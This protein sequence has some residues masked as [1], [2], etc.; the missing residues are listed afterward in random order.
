MSEEL[1]GIASDGKEFTLE[2]PEVIA[3][4]KQYPDVTPEAA[5]GSVITQYENTLNQVSSEEVSE[6]SETED[7]EATEET[8]KETFGEAEAES[9]EAL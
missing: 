3:Y 4:R 1:K 5:I 8:E 2:S 6:S 7:E 9:E